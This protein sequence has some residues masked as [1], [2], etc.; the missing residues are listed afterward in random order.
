MA[1]VW[2]EFRPMTRR[3]FLYD[4]A[5][6]RLTLVSIAGKLRG[7]VTRRCIPESTHVSS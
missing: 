5:Y 1:G 6:V 3:G 2:G 7:L 4:D